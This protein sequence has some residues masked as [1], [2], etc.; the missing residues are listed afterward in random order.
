[1]RL[2]LSALI[3]V[4]MAIPAIAR[5]TSIV[6]IWTEKRITI[7]ADSK[8]ILT[9]Q[10]GRVVGSQEFCKIYEVRGLVFAIAGLLK[11]EQISVIDEI[12]NSVELKDQNTGHKLP[13]TSL[14]VA[15][16][17]A[18]VK[19]LK[20]RGV[21]S[22]LRLPGVQL[23]IAGMIDGK[24]QM[25]R[26]EIDGVSI[27]GMYAMPT[28]SRRIAYPES[29]GHNGTDPKRGVEPIGIYDSIQRFQK[30]S[31]E[32]NAGDDVTVSRRLVAIEASDRL[33]SQAVGPPIA[34]I[35]IDK[36]RAHWIDKGACDWTPPKPSK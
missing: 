14:E 6:G 2:R 3:A 19:V 5:A 22:D 13:E 4:I 1:M 35:V 9:D 27:Q 28:S 20:A 30:I 8:G 31:P 18:V 7:S 36:K 25:I 21:T 26:V 15:A 16:V 23:L 10:N 32:W 34:T 17:A 29:R 11:A 33:V 24:L 12:E